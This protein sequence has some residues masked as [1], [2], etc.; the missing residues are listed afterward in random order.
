MTSRSVSL[1]SFAGSLAVGPREVS[2][3]SMLLVS[4]AVAKLLVF[5]GGVVQKGMSL[6]SSVGSQ[7]GLVR[8]PG[9]QWLAIESLEGSGI[10]L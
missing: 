7:P 10:L 8:V 3:E 5:M 9:S 6:V 2:L 4:E 1:F